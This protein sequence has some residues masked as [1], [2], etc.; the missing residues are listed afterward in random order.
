MKLPKG[1][2]R[3]RDSIAYTAHFDLKDF[4]SYQLANRIVAVHEVQLTQSSV[5][6]EFENVA[7]LW[8]QI[9]VCR[10]EPVD[11]HGALPV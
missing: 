1:D 8:R 11:W 10:N 9:D 2:L 7:L 6:R 4:A 5:E 3:D